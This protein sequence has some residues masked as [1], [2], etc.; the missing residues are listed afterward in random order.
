MESNID[1]IDVIWYDNSVVDY[2]AYFG[3]PAFESSLEIKFRN[4]EKCV[5][6]LCWKYNPPTK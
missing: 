2:K 6:Y 1:A 3:S 5:Y 4:L